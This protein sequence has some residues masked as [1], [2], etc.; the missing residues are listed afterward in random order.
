MTIAIIIAGL[1]IAG[2][3]IFSGQKE[4]KIYVP[5]D[6]DTSFIDGQKEAFL[7]GCTDDGTADLEM[8]TCTWNKIMQEYGI[9]K[10]TEIAIEYS[11]T[12][13]MPKKM[14]D[15]TLSCL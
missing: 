12:D 8:C 13:Y 10:F 4:E 15:I 5:L 2:A 1:L 11:K 14:E 9:D 7:G 6:D 3:I